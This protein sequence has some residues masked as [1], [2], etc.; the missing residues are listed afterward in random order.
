VQHNEIVKI[1]DS[2]FKD[3]LFPIPCD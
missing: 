1:D 2:I 3:N